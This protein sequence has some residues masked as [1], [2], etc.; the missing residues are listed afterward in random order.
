MSL[1]SCRMSL[2]MK[3]IGKITHYYNKIGVA[4]IELS[5]K[6]QVGDKIKIEGNK[7]EFEQTVDSIE[8][9]RKKVESAK[10]GEVVGIKVKEK[11][12]EG[13]LVSKLEE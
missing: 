2:N 13:A 11:I 8:I 5:G 6:L 4:I 12:R 10:A 3:P 9:D 7:N 1:V